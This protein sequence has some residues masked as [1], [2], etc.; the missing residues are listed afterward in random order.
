MYLKPVQYLSVA[1][2]A[3]TIFG[4]CSQQKTQPQSLQKTIAVSILPQKYFIDQ[5][6]GNHY[7]TIVMLPPGANHETFEPTAV[8]LIELSKASVYFYLGHLA[9]EQTL[10]QG[11][12]E[13]NTQLEFIDCSAN[14]ELLQG[15]CNHEHGEEHNHG[16]DPHTWI[17]PT[18]VKEMVNQMVAT[19]SKIDP[20][21][22]D[23]LKIGYE[24]VSKQIDSMDRV[25]RDAISKSGTKGVMLFH[26]ILSYMARDYG[27]KQYAI[28]EE[29]KE[30]S[31]Q[32]LKSVIEKARE[33]KIN[34]IF[35]QQEFDVER[36]KIVAKEIGAEVVIL[37]PLGYRWDQN[38]T[39]IINHL[40]PKKQ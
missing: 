33:A 12:R 25:L 22:S 20:D 35:V 23:S 6:S 24:K 29:G 38:I 7:N 28:E 10:L 40:S 11:I 39:N 15:A 14:V 27:F 3:L 19:L 5:L 30:P 36:A 18:T 2:I 21:F 13:S 37:D 31:P 32:Q 1:I 17:S 4:G 9:F 16:I 26:P 8:Q 34:I